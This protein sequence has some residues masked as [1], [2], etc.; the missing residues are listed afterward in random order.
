MSALSRPH[1]TGSRSSSRP[2]FS[3]GTR[4]TLSIGLV[5]GLVSLLLFLG[6]YRLQERQALRQVETQ[7][8]AL[9]TEMLVI[10]EWVAEYGG[11][12][13]TQPGNYYL[14]GRDGFYRK[15]PA[16]VTK[17]LSLLSNTKGYYRFHITSLR[18]K[19]PENA[20][21]L[22]EV[23]A[24]HQFEHDARPV[25]RIE[26]VDG[27]RVYRRMIPL[28]AKAACLECHASQGYKIGD[29]RGGLSVMIPLTEMDRALAASRRALAASAALIIALVMGLLYLLVR[30]VIVAPIGRLKAAAVAIS[31]GNYGVRCA[32]HTG[33]EL[34]VLGE[35][36]NRMVESL[37]ASRN[38]LQRQVAQRTGELKALSEIALTISRSGALERVLQEALEQVLQA[39]GIE[40]GAI[41]LVHPD[42]SLVLVADRGLPA[43]MQ[44]CIAKLSKGEGFLPSVLQRGEPFS[45]SNLADDKWRSFCPRSSCPAVLEGYKVL[46]SIPLRSRNRTLGALT[47]LR[48]EAGDVPSELIQ[49][50]TCVGNQL[51][52]A[53]ENARFQER[54]KQMAILDE[55]SRIARE[56]HDSLAQTLGWLNLKTEMLVES[57]R[58]DDVEG[59]R[60]EAQAIHRVVR[61]ACYDVRESIEGLRVQPTDGLVPTMAAYLSEFGRRNG[62]L[63]DLS[64]SNGECRLTPVAEAE[65]LRILQEALT[66]VRKHA[67]AGRVE[68]RLRGTAQM[69]EIHI[70]DDGQG[71]DPEALPLERHYGLRIMR[72][73]AER[74]GGE[75][76]IESKP[77]AGTRITVRLPA[78]PHKLLHPTAEARES[79]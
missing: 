40:T 49:F 11:V 21:D 72:E 34:E 58:S 52:V 75:F 38:A 76:H 74:L 24:L 55:R 73:R 54:V 50:L 6:L 35:T 20:P 26:V 60:Q 7:A 13:T 15:S 53:V 16:M 10:R 12:W 45:Q 32:I 41:H 51:G 78:T 23:E 62:L 69:V 18:L 8:Q 3:L 9:L 36:F 44:R 1:F 70:A 79:L 68:V 2:R 59:A 22:F 19:N 66:N 37:E 67:R 33:D 63:T 31:Q 17:E 29:I 77:G 5:I 42:G 25:S 64:V 57:L 28:Y 14:E 46:I 4:L 56:L 71:F 48:R 30:R 61:H 43:S 27:Q 65:A 39:V 47:L